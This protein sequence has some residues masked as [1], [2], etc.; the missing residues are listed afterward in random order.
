V[1]GQGRA[2]AVARI[3]SVLQRSPGQIQVLGV[4][5]QVDGEEAQATVKLRGHFGAN[6]L[7]RTGFSFRLSKENGA[8]KVT[9]AE[10]LR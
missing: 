2:W 5:V 8:W 3:R 6:E 4:A 7:W 9:S 10:E 1:L